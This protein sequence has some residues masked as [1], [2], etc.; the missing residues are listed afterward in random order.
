MKS[1]ALAPSNI[2]FIKYWGKSDKDLKLPLNGSV[3]MNLSAMNTITT[4]EFSKKYKA[5]SV[6]I[7][8]I[9]DELS[10]KKVLIHIEKI[11]D[12][13][14]SKLN[15]K[16]VSKNNFPSATGLSSSASAFAAL[17]LAV[18]NALEFNISQK[19]ISILA[20]LGSGSACRSI[21][22]GFVE[23]L[24]GT[25][26][27]TSYSY[28]IFPPGYFDVVDIVAVVSRE[29]KEVS[30]TEGQALS[31]TSPFMETRLDNIEDKIKAMKKYI[32]NKDFIKFGELV[33]N[34][35]LEMHAVM[36]TSSPAL[37]YLR[38][39]TLELISWVRKVRVSGLDVY[40]TLNTGQDVHIISQKQNVEILKN[41]LRNFKTIKKI[42]I[43]YPDYGARIINNHLF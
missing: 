39:E 36:M 35:A 20:R 37:L 11:R 23:W 10:I 31:I 30:S 13:V 7:D 6:K 15:C 25:T 5:D 38:P 41:K 16:V 27:N 12:I 3:S 32:E 26:S 21:P 43:N 18:V 9:T 1:T 24:K 29:K 4:V 28:S 17:T 19:G 2:A 33:E 40:F 42:I 8:G 34:D 14:G 22:D